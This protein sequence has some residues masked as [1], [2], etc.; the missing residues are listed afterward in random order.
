MFKEKPER[1]TYAQVKLLDMVERRKLRQ[2][3]KENGFSHTA[4]YRLAFGEQPITYKVMASMCH[5]ISPIEWLYFTDEKL[6][7]EPV[8]LPKWDLERPPKYV[9][10]HRYDYKTIAQKYEIPYISAYK[11]FVSYTGYPSPIFIRKLCP[12]INPVDFFIAG[13]E[14]SE[15]KHLNQFIPNRG[16]IIS[17]E[18]KLIFVIS[19]QQDNERNN[20]YTGCLIL[21][22]AEN[23][24]KLENLE[25]KGYVC[26]YKLQSFNIIKTSPR[27]LI[28]KADLE[29]TQ[30]IIDAVKAALS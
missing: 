17:V 21:S 14:D 12:E 5:F 8:L 4:V 23:S 2:W 24:I 29:F 27:T 3:C 10:E 15:I 20:S 6:P 19:T 22:D 28:E 11:I 1:P 26:P 18:D 25:S 30:K 13:E 16:D 9:K 7:F